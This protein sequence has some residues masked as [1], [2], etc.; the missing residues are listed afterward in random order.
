MMDTPFWLFFVLVLLGLVNGD[1]QNDNWTQ[2][3]LNKL[4]NLEAL[5]SRVEILEKANIELK[6][7]IDRQQ[8]ASS[9]ETGTEHSR[10]NQVTQNKTL[11]E[12][13]EHLEDLSKIKSLRS[14][15][16]YSLY[17]ITTS[18][19]Y[20][21]DP[22]GDLLEEPIEVFCD[23]EEKTTQIMHDKEFIVEI[24]HCE[25][26]FCY[27]L[28]ISYLAS[29]QQITTLMD[30]SE[31]CDQEITF[32]CFMSALSIVDSPVGVWLNR[33]QE[34][35][36]Y[37]EGAN[38]GAHMCKCSLNDSCSDSLHDQKCNCDANFIPEMQEDRGKIT[39]SSALPIMGFAYG[40][41]AYDSQIAQVQIGRLKC[42]GSKSIQPSEINDSCSNMKRSGVTTSGNYIL[43]NHD[44]AFCDMSKTINDPNIQKTVGELPFKDTMFSAKI[45]SSMVNGFLDTG[46]IT[47][48][49]TDYDYSGDFN[50]ESGIFTAG[51]NGLY[52]F[53][54]DGHANDSSEI[55]IDVY[56]NGNL[57]QILYDY[58]GSQF[59]QWWYMNL[60]EGDE[61]KLNNYH[62]STFKVDSKKNIWFMGYI[63]N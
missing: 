13:V 34:P 17:G 54:F 45:T 52:Q 22:D 59:S 10:G 8:M 63:I 21:I 50:K 37:F 38:H 47:F 57:D 5:E 7:I 62:A 43:N 19:L 42:R 1:A 36:T 29:L 35:E 11:E 46:T 61:I 20:N 41:V 28:N 55:R 12:R 60:D 56:K 9:K 24:P 48:E 53:F 26:P 2:N 32:A 3:V 39:N 18:G 33:Y 14:C 15:H 58:S 16:E 40:E 49:M 31:S 44:V 23:F 51:K 30:L 6:Q 27:Q 4:G 25:D